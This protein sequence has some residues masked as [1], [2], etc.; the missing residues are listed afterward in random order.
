MSPC[1]GAQ[2]SKRWLR[3]PVPRV[4]VR[5]S[6][7]KPISPRAGMR[8]SRRTRP[9]PWF[10]I[11]TIWPLRRAD[12]LGHDA[13]EI[14]GTV[15]HQVLHRLVPRPSSTSRVITS[16]WPDLAAR[17]PRGASSRSGSRAGARR[18]RRPGTCPASRSPRSGWPTLIARLLEQPLPEVA[19]GDVLPLAARRTGETFE[20]E[21]HGHGRLVDADGR[22][23]D[24]ALGVGDRLADLH[25]LDRRRPPPPRPARPRP[26]RP[27]SGPRRRRPP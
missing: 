9:V 24:R 26:P 16:G 3:R 7:R 2:P 10:T 1:H 4:S 23:G 15:D 12:L 17:S 6:E 8:Y 27:A 22:Q 11:F 5:N 14:L 13:D 18:G 21:Q 19:G 20:R 25:R